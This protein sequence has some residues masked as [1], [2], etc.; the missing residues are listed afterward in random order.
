[1]TDSKGPSTAR[2]A[3]A[4]AAMAGTMVALDLA[5]VGLVARPV[6]DSLGSLKRAKPFLP[7]AGLFYAM[8]AAATFVH[9]VR[10]SSTMGVAAKRAAGLGLVAYGT[11][12]LSG[13]A[14]IRDWP[15][16]LVPVDMAWGMVL[17]MAATAVGRAIVPPRHEP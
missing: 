16:A 6:Y 14:V 8:Y 3:L 4:I 12:E 13:A 2:T 9:A 10:P 11:F 5:W 1:M 7:A 15:P 17:T